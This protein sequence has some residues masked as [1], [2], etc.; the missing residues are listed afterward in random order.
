MSICT[1]TMHRSDGDLTEA[2][3]KLCYE[4][5][6]DAE[7]IRIKSYGS[8]GNQVI[9]LSCERYF[10][11]NGNYASLT[12]MMS[13]FDG[14]QTAD[15]VG[16][17]GGGGLLNISWGANADFAESAEKALKACGFTTAEKGE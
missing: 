17:G 7:N 9:L 10:F 14:V 15:I 3:E 16:S 8:A 4:L 11:R 2:A 13:E 5:R 12:V 6:P 1:I